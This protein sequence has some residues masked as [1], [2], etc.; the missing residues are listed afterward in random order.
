MI[1]IDNN[2]SWR[3]VIATAIALGGMIK[4]T[5][6]RAQ[7]DRPIIVAVCAP[8]HGTDGAGRDVETPNLA[9]QSGIYLYNQIVAFQKGMRSHPVMRTI[10]RELTENEIREIVAYYSILPPP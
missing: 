9:G 1:F 6:A 8:C 3:L 5:D 7:A 2:T 10:A 4:C